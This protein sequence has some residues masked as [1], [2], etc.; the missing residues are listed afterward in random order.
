MANYAIETHR[1]MSEPVVS[2]ETTTSLHEADDMLDTLDISS[3]AVTEGGRLVGV[4]SR[5]DLLRVG[6]RTADDAHSEHLLDLPDDPVESVMTKELVTV[7]P[8][9]AV[10]LAARQ[11]LEHGYHRV[12][13][14]NGG[15][16]VGVLSTRDLMA[17]IRDQRDHTVIGQHMSQPIITCPAASPVGEATALLE[18]AGIGGVVVVE[19]DWPV[20]MFTQVE[21]LHARDYEPDTPVEELMNQA[22]VCMPVSMRMHRAA[23]QSITLR[24]RRVLA[25]DNQDAVG[26][27]SGLDFARCAAF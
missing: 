5:T 19:D 27:L 23:A 21:A 7:E 9:A 26:I 20:G 22:F 3:L 16:P 15:E 14:V 4:V 11:M 8:N 6:R 1:Y 12:Y 17:V 2:V 10:K 25:V 18:E 13:V 24:T